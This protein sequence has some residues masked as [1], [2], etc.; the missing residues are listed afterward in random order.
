MNRSAWLAERQGGIGSS[1]APC[2]VGVGFRDALS[3]YHDKVN[4]IP[5]RPVAGFLR[6]GLDLEDIIA[7][8]YDIETGIEI[9]KP[10]EPIATSRSNPIQK[11]SVDRVRDYDGNIVELKSCTGFG[12]AWGET[13]TDQVPLGYKVQVVHQ[14]GVVGAEFAD[15]AALDVISWELRIYR[16]MSNPELFAWLTEIENRFWGEHVLKQIPPNLE[17][18]LQWREYVCKTLFTNTKIDLGTEA[19]ELALERDCCITQI[20]KLEA[21]KDEINLQIKTLMGTNAKAIAGDYSFSQCWIPPASVSYQREGYPRLSVR[22]LK[23]R[24]EY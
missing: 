20:K 4:P 21:R 8:R 23:P 24:E 2:L 12:E 7:K 10:K 14:L 19:Q 6:R 17:W 1:D 13:H 22:K 5:D 11:A 3:I 15:I 9:S 16:V 18:E